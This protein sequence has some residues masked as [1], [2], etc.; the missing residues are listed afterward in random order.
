PMRY[1]PH[2][3]A[4]EVYR[5]WNEHNGGRRQTTVVPPS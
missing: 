5:L 3:G 1:E 4:I 2:E